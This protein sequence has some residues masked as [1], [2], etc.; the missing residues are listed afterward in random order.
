MCS[1]ESPAALLG[2]ELALDADAERQR[3]SEASAEQLGLSL[4]EAAYGILEIA[5]F[6][7][8]GAVREVSVKRG[9]DPREYTLFAYGGAGPLHAAQ[10]ASLLGVSKIVI[11]ANPGLGSCIGLLA[12]DIREN[13]VRTAPVRE[14]Q[15]KLAPHERAVRP[16]VETRVS[17]ALAEQDVDRE[18]TSSSSG[19][20]TCAT[21]GWRRS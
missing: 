5:A 19:S 7:M 2:G 20:P 6:T 16:D 9:R 3:R 4:E 14:D 15:L 1:A 8:A 21:S 18:Q 13:G 10:L 17:E 12:A 11:P